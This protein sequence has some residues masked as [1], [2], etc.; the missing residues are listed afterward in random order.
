M[1]LK[2]QFA[3][4]SLGAS[5]DQQTGGLSVFDIV[6]EIRTPQLPIHL[7]SLVISL[8]LDNAKQEEMQGRVL[9]HLLTPDGKQTL[10]GQGELNVPREQRRL[11]AVFRFGGLPLNHFGSHRFVVSWVSGQS[12]AGQKQGEAILDF[13][14]SQATQ[15]AQG[16]PPAEKPPLSH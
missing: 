9:I 4:L 10:L 12:G 1:A 5:V 2:L 3:S 13:E 7:Q 14:V 8:V 6:D 16:V 11:K 15:V